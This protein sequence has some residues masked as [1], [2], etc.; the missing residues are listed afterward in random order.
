[1]LLILVAS[2]CIRLEAR[3]KKEAVSKVHQ[4]LSLFQTD[5][6]VHFFSLSYAIDGIF[7]NIHS[8][9]RTLYAV[10]KKMKEAHS[11]AWIYWFKVDARFCTHLRRACDLTNS[12]VF[13][14]KFHS[15]VCRE[16]NELWI[17]ARQYIRVSPMWIGV[18]VNML[19]LL[20]FISM[21]LWKTSI[22]WNSN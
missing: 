20:L 2:S 11:M 6:H 21:V 12:T 10:I 19:L 16:F 8:S 4:V 9:S 15:N 3:E 7:T 18:I 22:R 5:P 14:K 1:M 17:V 13:K